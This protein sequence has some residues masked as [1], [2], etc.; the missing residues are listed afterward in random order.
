[1]ALGHNAKSLGICGNLASGAERFQNPLPA[2][3]CGFKSLLRHCTFDGKEGGSRSGGPSRSPLK[4]STVRRTVR[5]SCC[6]RPF[7][8]PFCRVSPAASASPPSAPAPSPS[9]ARARGWRLFSRRCG[10]R[11]RLCLKTVSCPDESFRSRS[12]PKE[13][14]CHETTRSHG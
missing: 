3:A 4:G 14:D 13:A 8:C 6:F 2:R 9:R 11:T 1:M 10:R 5:R 7:T 12:P